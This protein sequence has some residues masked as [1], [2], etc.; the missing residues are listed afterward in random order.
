MNVG[1]TLLTA[2]AITLVVTIGLAWLPEAMNRSENSRT[3]AAVFR[4]TPILHLT[5]TNIVDVLAAVP[6]RERLGRAEWKGSVLSL[7]LLVPY[8]GGR[9]EAWFNDIEKLIDVSFFQLENVKRLL[10]KIVES[11]EEGERLLAAVD[12]RETDTW[13]DS[14]L[15]EL[16]LS[17]PAHN[18]K[19]RQRLRL[20]FTKA[21]ID[22][23]GPPAGYSAQS[24]QKPTADIAN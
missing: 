4:G 2:C 15:K 21:W 6:L 10:V 18:E 11:G 24:A 16:K 9:P 12:I 20:S 13:L 3:E 23:F 14:S 8:N 7:D 19:W 17:D 5:H 22:R 1:R